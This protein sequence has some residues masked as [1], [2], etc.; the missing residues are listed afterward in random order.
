MELLIYELTLLGSFLILA[1][2]LNLIW[3]YGGLFN[4]GVIGTMSVGAYVHVLLQRHFHLPFAVTVVGGVL[5]ASLVGYILAVL[6]RRIRRA[7][8]QVFTLAFLFMVY[9]LALGWDELTRGPLGFSGI[10]RPGQFRTDERY[11]LVVAVVAFVVGALVWRTVRSPF[12][13]LLE[14]SRDDEQAVLSLGKDPVG[15]KIKAFVFASALSGLAGALVASQL[16]Y[17]DPGTFFLSFLLSAVAMVLVGGLA[18]IRGTSIGGSMVFLLP[19]ALRFV[20]LPAQYVG[21]LR[22]VFFSLILL[23]FV[24]GK[25]KGLMGRIEIE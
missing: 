25:P 18:S 4:L 10:G 24:I 22:A 17:I 12:G 16:R 2:A 7:E 23:F 5:G 21:P 14:A 13:R 1:W 3:G 20:P 6:T 15:V 11:L 9:S 19:A 8:F